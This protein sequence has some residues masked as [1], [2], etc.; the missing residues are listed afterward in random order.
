MLINT[1]L[2]LSLFS[3]SIPAIYFHTTHLKSSGD[4][5]KAFLCLYFQHDK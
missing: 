1:F 5:H 4:R 2:F 3:F